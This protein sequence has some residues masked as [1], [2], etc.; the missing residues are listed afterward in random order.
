MDKGADR[1]RYLAPEVYGQSS[2]QGIVNNRISKIQNASISTVAKQAIGSQ[3]MLSKALEAT[4]LDSKQARNLTTQLKTGRTESSGD[5]LLRDV[6]LT[7]AEKVEASNKAIE[8]VGQNAFANEVQGS[9]VPQQTSESDQA[10]A[11]IKE[12]QDNK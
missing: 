7:K 4:K 2:D 12:T 1:G 6:P 3:E 8:Q 9:E 11:K 10:P 5:K